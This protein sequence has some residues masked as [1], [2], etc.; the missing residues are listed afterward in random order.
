MDKISDN[1]VLRWFVVRKTDHLKTFQKPIK[2]QGD[3][4]HRPPKKK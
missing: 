1:P 3:A 2:N 4:G